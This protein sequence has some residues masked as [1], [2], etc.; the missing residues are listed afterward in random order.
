MDLVYHLQTSHFLANAAYNLTWK[1]WAN[2]NA[3]QLSSQKSEVT[4]TDN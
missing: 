1:Q 2:Y 4:N 3:M